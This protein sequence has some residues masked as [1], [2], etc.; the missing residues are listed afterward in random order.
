VAV[1][2]TT[3]AQGSTVTGTVTNPAGVLSVVISGCG[4]SQTVAASGINPATGTFPIVIPLTQATG[5]C[6]LNFTS[7]NINGTQTMTPVTMTVTAATGPAGTGLGTPP[8]VNAP[9]LQSASILVNGFN[10]SA[11]SVIQ[12]V[13]SGP[14]TPNQVNPLPNPADFSLVGFDTARDTSNNGATN[15]LTAVQDG[16]NPNAIDVSYPS[17]VDPASY[18]VAAADNAA[19]TGAGNSAVVGTSGAD[20]GLNNPLGTVPLVGSTGPTGVTT[21]DT[22]APDLVSCAVNPSN[23]KQLIYT[24]DKAVKTTNTP[25]FFGFYNVAGT[26]TVAAAIDPA[27][28]PGSTQVPIDYTASVGPTEV[29]CALAQNAVQGN[30][31]GTMGQSPLSGVGGTTDAPDLTSIT[32]VPGNSTQFDFHFD[33]TVVSTA[34]PADFQ[35]FLNNAT[36][37][38]GA[39]I[40]NVIN[41][42]T[43]RVEFA[44]TLTQANVGNVV[45]GAVFANTTP[46]G[47]VKSP[48]SGF[49]NTVGSEPISGIV[50]NGQ[51][52]DGPQ[53]QSA[54]GTASGLSVTYTFNPQTSGL[55]LPA[56]G[57]YFVIDNA[58]NVTFGTGTPTVFGNTVTVTFSAIALAN[59]KGA[60]V[61]SGAVNP[62]NGQENGITTVAVPN[63]AGN[64]NAP[65][66]VTLTVGP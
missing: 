58:G 14:V 21:G 64:Q 10:A 51:I 30:A 39:S 9:T 2:P 63:T 11:Q 44:P 25:N 37:L 33:E 5:S 36:V 1:A 16:S 60:G 42:N 66:L 24:F 19:T 53:L 22:T 55:G 13:F 26:L 23:P 43:V 47:G 12:Y 52:T 4:V 17:Q 7:N 31:S 45:L 48:V 6:T 28:V 56:V 20:A 41:S 35:V 34:T 50:T 15:A 3:T 57:G 29:R 40:V 59:A 46:S 62:N 65:G 8:V 38:A 49:F 18:T 27:F 61:T 54:T 32:A